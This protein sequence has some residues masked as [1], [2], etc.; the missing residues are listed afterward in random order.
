MQRARQCSAWLK[1][2]G[3]PTPLVA[4]SGNGAHLYWLLDQPYNR[5]DVLHRARRL[6]SWDDAVGRL[7]QL[8]LFA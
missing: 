3:W 8:E 1:Q 4:D 7:C 2:R 5:H 6:R